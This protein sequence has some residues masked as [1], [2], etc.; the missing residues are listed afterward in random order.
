MKRA[1]CTEEQIIGVSNEA[2]S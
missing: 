1:R 2:E